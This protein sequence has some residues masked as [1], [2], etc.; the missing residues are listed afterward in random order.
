M[1]IGS[2]F[3]R[4]QFLGSFG[5]A[6]AGLVLGSFA[7]AAAEEREASP[8]KIRVGVIGCGSVSGMYLPDLAASPYVELVST[9][10]RIPERAERRAREFNV[11]HHYP[12]IEAM[13][14]GEPF[15]LFVNLTDMQEHGRLNRM[16]IEAGRHVWSEKP[17]ASTYPEGRALVDLAQR[18]K[19]RIWG[20]PIVVA[21]PQFAYMNESIRSGRI[22]HVAAAHASYGHLGPDWSPFFYERGGGSMPDLGVYNLATLTGLL[23]PARSV[24]AMTS[25]ITPKRQI[26]DQGEIDVTAEDNAMV[27][28]DHGGGTLS[29]TQCG[30][31]YFDPHGHSGSGQRKCTISIIGNRGSLG[32]VGYD[33]APQGVEIAT[34]GDEMIRLE[35]EDP[36]SYVWQ[37]GASLVAECLANGKEPPMTPEHAL[38]IVEIMDAARQSQETGRR[39]DVESTFRWPIDVR[40]S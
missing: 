25:I 7:P 3:D 11:P 18:A 15:D 16:A 2:G 6:G 14:A 37:Q 1:R 29:H 5:T 9:C 26:V 31:N 19:L 36:G 21:S 35:V 20:A 34:L 8:R 30:F 27:V 10:D 13:L 39:V 23:G 33:W 32:L 24:I 12:H 38:H 17:L 40:Q 28:L 4:R 22:G